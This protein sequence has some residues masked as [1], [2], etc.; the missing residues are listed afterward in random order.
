MLATLQPSI[1]VRLLCTA[2]RPHHAD[3]CLKALDILAWPAHQNRREQPYNHL[4][5][6]HI[7]DSEIRVREFTPLRIAFSRHVDIWHLHWPDH[8]LNNPS[9]LKTRIK[10]VGLLG[11]MQLARAKGT[12]IV[13]TIHNLRSHENPHPD[14]EEAFWRRFIPKL[15]GV[16]S[17]SAAGLNEAKALYPHLADIP[18]AITPIGHFKGVYPDETTKADARTRL[19]IASAAKVLVYLGHIRPYKNLPRLLR[20]FK[21]VSTPDIVLVVAGAASSPP[22]ADEVRSLAS[23]DARVKVFLTHVPADEIQFFLRAADL[24]VLPF[25][26]TLNSSTALL[27]L[28]F[29]CPLLLPD[30]GSLLELREEVGHDW[31]RTY[32]GP[33]DEG[34]ISS[35]VEWALEPRGVAPNLDRRSWV[36]IARLTVDLY[37]EVLRNDP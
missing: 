24:V 26:E 19:G 17:P 11:L 36:E 3:N 23:N 34:V 25:D 29:E 18:A 14:L 10:K 9:R 5:Y 1:H 27:A 30:L 33:L 7:Q 35:A 4:L 8:F 15:A 32:S 16:M 20:A 37:R 21:E 12:R 13:W 2:K 28:S 22:L 6:T 31:V